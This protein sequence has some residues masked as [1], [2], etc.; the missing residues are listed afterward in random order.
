MSGTAVDTGDAAVPGTSAWDVALGIVNALSGNTTDVDR[1]P[2]PIAPSVPQ[3][4][5]VLIAG[6]SLTTLLVIGLVAFG[7]MKLAK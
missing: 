1:G 7:V 4:Q 2:T 6:L 3:T 5:G